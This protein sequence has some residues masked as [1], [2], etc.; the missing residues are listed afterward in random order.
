MCVIVCVCVCNSSNM[1]LQIN[2][3]L[4]IPT[5]IIPNLSVNFQPNQM[6]TKPSSLKVR[7]TM[8]INKLT[9]IFF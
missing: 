5:Q 9:G 4:T 6:K 7:I 1:T 8:E 3:S 2:C